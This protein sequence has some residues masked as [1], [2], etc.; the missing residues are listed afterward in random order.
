[1]LPAGCEPAGCVTTEPQP[2]P[3]TIPRSIAKCLEGASTATATTTKPAEIRTKIG[4]PVP[5]IERAAL[6]GVRDMVASA[7]HVRHQNLAFLNQ[8]HSL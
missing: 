4:A 8:P 2:G 1:M 7:N 5:L 6:T 3:P